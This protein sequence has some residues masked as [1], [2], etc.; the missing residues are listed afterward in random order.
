MCYYCEHMGESIFIEYGDDK[1]RRTET[2]NLGGGRVVAIKEKEETVLLDVLH[3]PDFQAMRRMNI[4]PTIDK[5]GVVT[6]SQVDVDGDRE[7][8]IGTLTPG[9]ELKMPDKITVRYELKPTSPQLP[10]VDKKS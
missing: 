4:W 2:L 8:K 5:N 1:P 9:T 3:N 6:I 10:T 7:D